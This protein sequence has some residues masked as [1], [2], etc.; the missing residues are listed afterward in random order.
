MEYCTL[1]AYRPTSLYTRIPINRIGPVVFT[2]CHIY[3][4]RCIYENTCCFLC[5]HIFFAKFSRSW[6]GY[7]DRSIAP[8]ILEPIS[9]TV[10]RYVNRGRCF[11][12]FMEPVYTLRRLQTSGAVI[13]CALGD[14]F[15]SRGGSIL[16]INTSQHPA[17]LEYCVA[18]R[19]RL[20]E[21]VRT[22]AWHLLVAGL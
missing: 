13:G 8:G 6:E 7:P 10:Q 4:L 16:C 21:R 9:E 3:Y 5:T 22:L 1:L 17:S 15:I 2:F 18:F 14:P 19:E 11:V 20:Q 12:V